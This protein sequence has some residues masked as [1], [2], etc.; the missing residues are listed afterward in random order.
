[1]ELLSNVLILDRVTGTGTCR[2]LQR[3]G[4][5]SPAE[6]I[7]LPA[8]ELTVLGFNKRQIEQIHHPDLSEVQRVLDW[9]L[10]RPRRQIISY[11]CAQ[12]PPLLKEIASP[13]LLLFCEG[14]TELL[15]T[16]QLAIVGC[17]T[18]S[19]SGRETARHFAAEL[20]KY[21]LTITSGLAC[22][23]DG[24]AHVGALQAEGKT[25]GVL[26]SGLNKVYPRQHL[27]LAREIR[28]KGLLLSEF[29]P[30]TPPLAHHFP[31]RNRIVSGLSLG[32]LV[33]EAAKRSG[34]LITARLAAEQGREVFAV[35][36]SINNLLS[37]GCHHLI[38]QGAKLTET[39]AD[40]MEELPALLGG[41]AQEDESS[42]HPPEADDL[43]YDVLLDSVGYE[44]TSVDL[45][46]ARSNFS[47]D[48][49]LEKLLSLELAGRVASMPGGYIRIKGG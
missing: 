29:W 6:L 47:V 43:S 1:M 35:P 23:I 21:G 33:V 8:T 13:P 34:S 14:D 36:G 12:Y 4:N 5:L 26:G 45:L 44:V 18:P 27:Q 31:R 24:L 22:G 9:Q 10:A 49:V 17:R 16:P 41:L 40:I 48:V 30:D 11:F 19:V 3:M 20:V 32:V 37:H 39:A 28:E 25:I 42:N 46:V 38:R 15:T 2:L 7:A